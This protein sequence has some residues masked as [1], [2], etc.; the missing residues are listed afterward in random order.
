MNKKFKKLVP[1][2]LLTPAL[3]YYLLFWIRPVLRAFVESVTDL[4]GK[5]SFSNY[6]NVFQDSYFKQAFSNSIIF[7]VFSVILSFVLAFLV[8]LLLNRKF[9]GANLLL[10]IALV[11]MAFPPTAV[12][13][14]W[15]TGFT[16]FGW[17]NNIL[18]QLNLISEPILWLTAKG[19]EALFFLIFIDTWTVMPSVMI[20]LLAG[21]QNLNKEYE[22]AAVILGASKFQVIKD[23]IMPILRPTIV[24]AVIL[25][26]IGALQVWM[27][28]VMMFGYGRVPFLVERIA[29]YT[30]IVPM[31][32]NSYKMSLT[33]SVVVT[34]IVLVSVT[35]YLRANRTKQGGVV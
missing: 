34:I 23:I 25:R 19:N 27:I 6:I 22:E 10:F 32:E 3:V 16:T 12:A 31:L 4:E 9:R 35:A 15:K 26:M 1:Y 17:I 24:T 18:V 14:L 5:L 20:I 2:V 30:D 8:A 11:P 28:A 29:Y 33:Y 21:L 13:I 7:A